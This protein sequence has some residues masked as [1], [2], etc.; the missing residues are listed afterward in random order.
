M[1]FDTLSRCHPRIWPMVMI[2]CCCSA[3]GLCGMLTIANRA[4]CS[5]SR[6]E[7]EVAQLAYLF[8]CGGWLDRSLVNCG[9]GIADVEVEDA[10]IGR[11]DGDVMDGH[12]VG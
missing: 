8:T 4:M 10:A 6:L 5:M 2:A 12:A 9:P 3:S 1:G 7:R 11:V